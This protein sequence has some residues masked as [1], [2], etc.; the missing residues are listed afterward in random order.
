MPG[1]AAALERDFS[2]ASNL[3]T[4]HRARL[5]PVY[6]EMNMILHMNIDKIPPVSQSPISG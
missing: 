5:D 3:L 1:G 4:V 2:I 6:V